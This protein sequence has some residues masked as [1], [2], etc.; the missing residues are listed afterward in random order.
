MYEQA[1]GEE[2]PAILLVMDTFDSITDA[3][4]REE[5]E[6]ITTQIAREGGSVGIHLLI[7]AGRQNALRA[8]LLANVKHQISLYLIDE[9]ETRNIVGRTDLRI[10]EIPGRGVV[11]LDHP[12]LFQTA[13][14][15]KGADTLDVIQQLQKECRLMRNHWKGS[16]PKP[17]PMVPE[18]LAFTELIQHPHTKAIIAKGGIPFAVD[19]EAVE[20]LELTVVEDKNTLIL[21]DQIES[22]EQ[23][24]LTIVSS[25][26]R[27]EKLDVGLIDNAASG[28]SGVKDLVHLYADTADE[29]DLF[30][31]RL[32]KL[33]ETRED[34]F[35]QVQ[36][37]SGGRVT[38]TEFLKEIR[39]MVVMITDVSF[40][41]ETMS[42]TAQA[43]LAKL[44]E[45]GARAGIYFVIGAVYG[46]LER[47]YDDLAVIVKK[48]KTGVLIGRITDQNIL[49][50]LNRPYKEP[51]LLPYEAYYI[52]HGKA[53]KLKLAAPYEKKRK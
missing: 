33:W 18:T 26:S 50:V 24:F 22:V 8:P 28:C 7:S 52:K 27:N 37:A 4:Y 34:A 38:L 11:K 23:T 10:E 49:E 46:A 35:R 19:F 32:Q 21:S 39:P 45:S 16:C 17:I 30:V 13:L 44:I 43:T 42:F 41:A 5:F 1:S 6:K 48:Q 9:I 25:T 31:E 36:L 47:Q 51:N 2:I 20:P 15:V 12:V 14:P 29:M 40:V 53:E 3:P